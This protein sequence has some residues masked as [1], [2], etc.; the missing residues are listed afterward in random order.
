MKFLERVQGA[1][2]GFMLRPDGL[3]VP[4][5]G[6]QEGQPIIISPL[7]N[8]FYRTSE[9]V[10]WR[11]NHLDH[12]IFRPDLLRKED[13]DAVWAAMLVESHN[14]VYTTGLN[15]YYRA[16][17]E[18]TSFIQTWGYEELKH[19]LVLRTYL[20]MAAQYRPDLVDIAAL[21]EELDET[22]AG[23]W[24][25]EEKKW[26]RAQTFTYTTVQE[27]VTG[28][29]YKRFRNYTQEPFLKE[30]LG[31]ISQDE[32]RHCQYY[33]DKGKQELA[34]DRNRLDEVDDTLLEFQMPGPTFIKRYD[35]HGQAMLQVAN[36]GPAAIKEVLGKVSQLT[37]K[38]HLAKLTVDPRYIKKLSEEWGID[39]IDIR[40]IV[41]LG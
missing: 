4:Q 2:N 31:L 7:F 27:V 35:R 12:T 30:I 37:G 39:R 18:M 6:P 29:F 25:E 13:T 41:G 17:H 21:H 20:E 9:G 33:L 14:P 23:P 28:I 11:F 1:V 8:R 5:E 15:E 24:G 26:T 40:K 38:M 22:R 34:E 10:M 3:V 19:Y 32:Y 36:L 16:D